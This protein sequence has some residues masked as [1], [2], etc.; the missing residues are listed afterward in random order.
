[1]DEAPAEAYWQMPGEPSPSLGTWRQQHN[2]M[3]R[4]LGLDL[5]S[6]EVPEMVCH[7]KQLNAY[8][9]RPASKTMNTWATREGTAYHGGSRSN[10]R[11]AIDLRVRWDPHPMYARLPIN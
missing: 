2:L 6:P 8:G 9:A 10:V 7:P 3:G 4:M 5:F 1:L 11:S